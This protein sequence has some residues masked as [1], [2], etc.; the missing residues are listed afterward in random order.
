M[1]KMIDNP[2]DSQGLVLYVFY[3]PATRNWDEAEKD[4]LRATSPLVNGKQVMIFR[5]PFGY[6]IKAMRRD[7]RG[8]DLVANTDARE[9]LKD[10]LKRKQE[11]LPI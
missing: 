11:R 4:A 10:A 8:V 3:D 9:T 2:F 5:V 7:K 1:H 6:K